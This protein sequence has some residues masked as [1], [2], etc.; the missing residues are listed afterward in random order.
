MRFLN[1]VTVPK[2]V[3]GGTLWDFLTTIVFQNV[4]KNEG[5]HFGGIQKVSKKVA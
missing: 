5:G 4:E 2:N 1:S 3:K